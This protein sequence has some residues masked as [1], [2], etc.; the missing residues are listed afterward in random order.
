MLAP[1]QNLAVFVQINTYKMAS[2][3]Y[4]LFQNIE[5]CNVIVSHLLLLQDTSYVPCKMELQRKGWFSLVRNTLFVIIWI[6]ASVFLSNLSHCFL[7]FSFFN[8]WFY[9]HFLNLINKY[10]ISLHF[11]YSPLSFTWFYFILQLNFLIY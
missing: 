8:Q 6:F 1:H 5:T 4:L 11:N 2:R 3:F 9:S 7:H 10:M